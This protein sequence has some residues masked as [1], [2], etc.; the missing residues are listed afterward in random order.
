LW[1]ASMALPLCPY[2][3]AFTEAFRKFDLLL[4]HDLFMTA[5][6]RETHYVL[7]A[8]SHLE[9]WGVAYT[10]NECHCVPFLVLRKKC[11]EPFF[12]ISCLTARKCGVR[13]GDDV[14]VETTRGKVRMKARVDERVAKGVVLVPHGWTVE[15]M[16]TFSPT[17]N[18][19]SLY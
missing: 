11:M 10:Y 5:A 8:C 15:S 12:E 19:G 17:C 13:S 7:S 2:T 9:K 6:G 1:L 16:P 18:A 3:N 14:V 4:V